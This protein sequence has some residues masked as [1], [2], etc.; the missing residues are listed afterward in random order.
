MRIALDYGRERA[1]FDVAS[2]HLVADLRPPTALA[3]PAAAVRAALEGPHAFPPLRRALTPDDHVAVVLD[4]ELPHLAELL[5]PVL[6]HIHSAGVSSESITLLCPPP[7]S[8]QAWIDELPDDFQD[9]HVEVC[10]LD[11]R[12]R[13]AYLA[14]TKQGKRL[15]LNRTL[16]ESDQIVV[17]SG[18][19][20]DPLLGYSGAEGSLYPALSDRETRQEMSERVN[21]GVP[22]GSPWPA[23]R[24]ATE[25]AWLLGAPFFVQVIESAGD[26]VAQVVAGTAESSLEGQRVLDAS[27]RRSVARPADLVIAGISGDPSRHTFAILAS[28]LACA[29]RVVRPGGRI[30]LL[31]QA[32]PVLGPEANLLRNTDDPREILRQLHNQQTV[33]FAPVL[34]WAAAA[35]QAHLNLLTPLPDDRVEELFAT[36]LHAARE[37]QRL[38]DAGGSCLFLPDAHKMLAVVADD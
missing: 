21:L 5:V 36:P 15:Y 28:A 3:D 25:T 27:W 12:R 38:I 18:R 30:A 7:S 1:E 16:V 11:D 33:E 26:G 6:E 34:R 8:K 23:R 31:T 29:A 35:V 17:L 2:E 19:R 13:M 22:E 37:V 4:E 10:D 20:Y 32:E 24:A 14:T 9:V